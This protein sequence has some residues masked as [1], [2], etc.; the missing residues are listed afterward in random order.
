MFYTWKLNFVL[1]LSHILVNIFTANICKIVSVLFSQRWNNTH[2]HTLTQLLFLTKYKSWSNAGSST[3]NRCYSFNVI[4]TLFCQRWNN[5]DKHTSA[6]LPF[7]IKFQCWN[8]VGL[9]ALNRRNSVDVVSTLI[10]Q[11]R[12]NV[13]KCTSL[14]FHF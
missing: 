11:R 4:S 8:N 7:S 10:C 13:D 14:N 6:Q 9:S 2:E 5:I 3:L 1:L 12:N